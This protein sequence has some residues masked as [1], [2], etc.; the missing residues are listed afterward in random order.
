MSRLVSS[1]RAKLVLAAADSARPE[2][3]QVAP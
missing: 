3:L 1:F 2:C